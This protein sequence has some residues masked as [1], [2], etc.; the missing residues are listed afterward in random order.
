VHILVFTEVR[1]NL[2]DFRVELDVNVFLF[3]KQDR[4]LYTHTHTVRHTNTQ[5][6]SV[7]YKYRY[8]N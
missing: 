5:T 8:T 3:T 4:M 1:C 6:Q 2:T 7:G